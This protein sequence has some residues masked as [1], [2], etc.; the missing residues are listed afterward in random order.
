MACSARVRVAQLDPD[1]TPATLRQSRSCRFALSLSLSLALSLARGKLA[2]VQ[3]LARSRV[4]SHP[5]LAADT[6]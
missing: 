4:H 2:R 6:R 3:S 5:T 1:R